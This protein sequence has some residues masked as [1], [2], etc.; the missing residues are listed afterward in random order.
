[1]NSW[2]EEDAE[3]EEEE[4]EDEENAVEEED[5]DGDSR[6]IASLKEGDCEG[7]RCMSWH[8]GGGELNLD[9]EADRE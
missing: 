9:A 7:E 5:E 6:V 4:E 1:M 8:G 2:S 3:E